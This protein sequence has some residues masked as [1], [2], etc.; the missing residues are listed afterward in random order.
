MP[1]P[2]ELL[3]HPVSL[4]IFALY[5][6]LMLWEALAPGRTLPQVRGW[7]LKGLAAFTVFFFLSSY[8]PLL[9]D[10]HLAPYQLFDLS[11]LGVAG[12][13]VVGLLLYELG[14]Y[15]WHRTMHR[16]DFLW[17]SF[18]QLHHSAERLDTYSAFYTSPLDMAGWTLLGSLT[19]VVVVGVV[20]QAATAIILLTVFFSIFQHTN[21]R[22]PRWLGYFVQRPESHTIHHGKGIH[23]FNY[24]DLPLFDI[25]FGTF[26]NPEGFQVKTGFYPGASARL[27]DMLRFV[28]VSKPPTHPLHESG[29]KPVS[30]RPSN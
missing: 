26:R 9:W 4:V 23:A 17:R 11:G 27:L 28:D 10:R 12:G 24:S 29:L 25:L 8:L 6:G 5:G 1:S 3:L 18:H 16:Y 30:S 15:W 19:L 2:L 20:P 7:K 13:T 21:I 14:V 22:T